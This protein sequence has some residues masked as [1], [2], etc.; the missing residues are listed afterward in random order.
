MRSGI[1]PKCGTDAVHGARGAFSW[2]G[3]Q[4]VRVKTSPLVRGTEV[5]TYICARC[6]YFEHHLADPGKLAEVASSWAHITPQ[7]PG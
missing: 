2:G 4:G 1:C 3:E 6:G 5:D 7:R